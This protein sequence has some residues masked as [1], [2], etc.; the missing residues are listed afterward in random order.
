MTNVELTTMCMIRDRKNN[1][2]VVQDRVKS[3]KGI[4]FPG[5]HVEDGESII[6]AAIREVKE[7]TG[8]DVSDLQPCGIIHWFNDQTGER[9]I[10]FNFKTDSWSG[11]LLSE[12][13]EG[14]VFWVDIEE[15]H[16]LNL[17][18]GFDERLPMFLKD[19][20][21]E[22]FGTWNDRGSSKMK[23]F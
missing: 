16:K 14:K 4:N 5:G 17:A 23:L 13:E 12:T 11:E 2:V 3:W 20:Y 9:Y 10:V 22:G 1:R 15:L 19:K 7:E 18:E 8:L 6:D 21:I